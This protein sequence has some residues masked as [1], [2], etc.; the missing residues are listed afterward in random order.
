MADRLIRFVLQAGVILAVI[1]AL[2]YKIFELD[3]Y[4]VAK[5]LVLNVAALVVALLLVARRRSLWFDVADGLLA[6]FLIWSAA[7]A[8]FATNYW[9][10][11]RSLGVTVSGAVIFWARD[12]P[13]SVVCIAPILVAA[14]SLCP[15]GRL[16]LT[17]AYGLETEYFSANRAPVARSETG[18]L[19]HIWRRLGC[20]RSCGALSPP[21]V[22]SGRWSARSERRCSGRRWCYPDRGRRG[23]LFWLQ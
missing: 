19:W 23:W 5:E 6:L 22:P 12:P 14:R 1:A 2:P 10:A 13:P 9:V 18:I 17:Q 16:A 8:L 3:R 4:F 20:R 11:Q 15:G 7:S 21:A